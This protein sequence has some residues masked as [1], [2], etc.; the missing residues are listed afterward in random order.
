MLN[1]L[2]WPL[3]GIRMNE[4]THL[5]FHMHAKLS[6]V[7]GTIKT[8]FKHCFYVRTGQSTVTNQCDKTPTKVAAKYPGDGESDW[9]TEQQALTEYREAQLNLLKKALMAVELQGLCH[10]MCERKELGTRKV[11]C[12]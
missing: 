10:L 11:G 3:N 9:Y 12:E 4:N 6:S 5:K 1:T 8:V 2:I 7:S